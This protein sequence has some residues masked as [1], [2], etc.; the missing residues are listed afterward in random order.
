MVN[1]KK[2]TKSG[3]IKKRTQNKVNKIIN[4]TE[5]IIKNGKNKITKL[6]QK[7]I[8]KKQ[9]TDSYIKK[10]PEKSVGIAAGIGALI[11]LVFAALIIKRKR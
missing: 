4:K 3:G 9:N 11:G 6:K 8:K 7:A 2:S 1:K 10:N 5:K